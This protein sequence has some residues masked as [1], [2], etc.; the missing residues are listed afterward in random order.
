MA[1]LDFAAS[2]NKH[3]GLN[4][5]RYVVESEG[6]GAFTEPPCSAR[7]TG[8]HGRSVPAPEKEC[9]RSF[10]WNGVYRSRTVSTIIE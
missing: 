7:Q 8:E 2:S 9:A 10:Y 6:G 3:D 4:Q 5:L 1:S